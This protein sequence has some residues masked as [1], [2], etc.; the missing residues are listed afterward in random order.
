MKNNSGKRGLI[1]ALICLVIVAAVIA[2]LV[3]THGNSSKE[4]ETTTTTESTTEH[5]HTFPKACDVDPDLWPDDQREVCAV[6]CDVCGELV[7]NP[8]A[9]DDANKGSDTVCAHNFQKRTKEFSWQ[10]DCPTCGSTIK[11]DFSVNMG[12]VCIYC[13]LPTTEQEYTGYGY[14]SCPVC[15]ANLIINAENQHI[16]VREGQNRYSKATLVTAASVDG[17]SRVTYNGLQYYV[18]D[19][20]SG[21]Y[22]SLCDKDG[23]YSGSY[24]DLYAFQDGSL[25]KA[26]GTP[27]F[28]GDGRFYTRSGSTETLYDSSGN[29]TKKVD[30]SSCTQEPTDTNVEPAKATN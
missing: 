6:Y 18:P 16:T 1:I 28:I 9:S 19:G 10:A 3:V 15:G 2:V 21:T 8:N 20:S 4:E 30:H 11:R 29:E 17:Y 26:S 7:M 22:E 14:T 24:K 25:Q 12:T 27:S 13:E 23:L 5:T